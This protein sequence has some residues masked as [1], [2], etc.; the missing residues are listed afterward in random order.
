MQLL[1]LLQRWEVFYALA[2]AV[3]GAVA[4]GLRYIVVV[5]R[6]MQRIVAEFSPN[7]G[8]SLRDAINRIE[9]CI[10][11][12]VGLGRRM[13]GEMR[14]A[15]FEATPSGEW[16]WASPQWCEIA[17]LT[18]SD[19]S[20]TGWLSA[21]HPD[22]RERVIEEWKSCC[23]HQRI[24]RSEFRYVTPAGRTVAVRA[25]AEPVRNSKGGVVGFVGSAA[26]VA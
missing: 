13:M 3:A 6:I 17:G 14:L 1:D 5:H 23:E 7:G 26:V 11:M 24:F 12:Q 8:G 21:V 18:L 25:M 2:V 15:V 20:G 4:G 10:S 9:A 19:A 16:V 22:D